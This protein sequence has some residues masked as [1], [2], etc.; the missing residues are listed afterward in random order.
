[1]K[2]IFVGSFLIV[3]FFFNAQSIGNSPYA[4]YGIGDVKYD[5][6]VETNSMGGIFHRIY[7]QISQIVLIL[8]IQQPMKIWSLPLFRLE[9]TNENNFFKSGLTDAKYTK[10]STY[11][12]N[13]SIAFPL[14]PKVKFGLG[15]QPYSSK[16][17]NVVQTE[18]LSDGICKSKQFS[19]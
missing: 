19:W 11:L 14:S 1:M 18:M 13:I 10:H 5:N 12:S 8:K 3:G 6:T 16:N 17:Y 15:Y 9:A 7:F 4:A 2:K